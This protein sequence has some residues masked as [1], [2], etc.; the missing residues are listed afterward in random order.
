MAT[1]IVHGGR[2]RRGLQS[3]VD[4]LADAVKVTLGPKGRNVVLGSS[5]GTPTITNDGVTIA[6]DIEL[7][8]P[9][10]N[11]G[12]ELVKQVASRTNDVAGDGTTTATVLAQA[13]LKAGLRNVAAGADPLALRRGMEAAVAAAVAAVAELAEAVADRSD[14]EHV[15]TVSAGDPAIGAIVA[16]AFDQVGRAGVITVEDSNTFG[17]ELEFAEG[18]QFDNGYLSPYFVTDPDAMEAVLDDCHV[19]LYQGRISHLAD[20]LPVMELVAVT[21][22][23]LVII[24]DDVDGEALA[25]LVVN[26]AR[27]V[28]ASV[29]IK[30]PG[31]GERRR[32][33]LGDLAVLTGAQVVSDE[34]GLSLDEVALDDLGQ[35][36]RVVATRD[37]T[38]VI[39][40]AGSADEVDARVSQLQHQIDSTEADFDREKLEERVAKLTGGVA[41]VRVG[42]ATDLELKERKLRI[43]DAVSA[44]RSAVAEGV[45]PGGGV[46]LLRAREAV[47]A[48]A[49]G[50]GSADEATGAR[51]VW[52]A[53]AAPIRQIAANAGHQPG[54]V[55]AHVERELGGMGLN[56]AT[57]VYEDLTKAGVIDPAMVVRVA[58]ENAASVV[59]LVL[60]TEC[61][62]A[63]VS[64]VSEAGN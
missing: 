52:Q 22:R 64:D 24:A 8:D 17:L 4:K 7:E 49:A 62:L 48:V 9:F 60:T 47:A 12:A 21:E 56:A 37:T 33:M 31:F 20:L 3:G 34:I 43:E 19:L 23:P 5:W 35:A 45:V 16:E 61:L 42:A 27:G 28:F 29:A 36:R 25:T 57:G 2:A 55:V 53:L 26:R 40:G 11:M 51:I 54:V 13:M 59:G 30:A 15:A 50:L 39:D 44:T 32:D 18:M 10:E 46:A 6:R 58:L 41:V 14:V 1:Q 38:T 63:D